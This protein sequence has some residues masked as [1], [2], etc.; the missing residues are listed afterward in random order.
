LVGGPTWSSGDGAAITVPS[1][2]GSINTRTD[3]FGVPMAVVLR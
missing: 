1:S 3:G 2:L